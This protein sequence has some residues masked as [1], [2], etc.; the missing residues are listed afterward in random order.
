MKY[1]LWKV[2]CRPWENR[3]SLCKEQL[4]HIHIDLQI[5]KTQPV[6]E[7]LVQ[8]RVSFPGLHLVL[9]WGREA[10]SFPMRELLLKGK[11]LRVKNT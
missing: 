6:V 5:M 7:V 2:I 1:N 8:A 10:T 3:S 4:R 11:P 9:L